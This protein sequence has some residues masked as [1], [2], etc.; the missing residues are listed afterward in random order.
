VGGEAANNKHASCYPVPFSSASG[1]EAAD[2]LPE[3]CSEVYILKERPK[4]ACSRS[5]SISGGETA[6]EKHSGSCFGAGALYQ[7]RPK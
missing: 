3:A 5:S 4:K 2:K 7:W 6:D 1:G